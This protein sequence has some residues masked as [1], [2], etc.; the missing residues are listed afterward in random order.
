MFVC[1]MQSCIGASSLDSSGV[2]QEHI[3]IL[4]CGV[5]QSNNKPSFLKVQMPIISFLESLSESAQHLILLFF[6]LTFHA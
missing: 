6:V 2:M 3:N 1:I 5:K 4:E